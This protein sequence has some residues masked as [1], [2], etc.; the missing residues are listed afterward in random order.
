MIAWLILWFKCK[1]KKLS[2][3]MLC[4]ISKTFKLAD[5]TNRG[6]L[7]KIVGFH[8]K[9]T[10]SNMVRCVKIIVYAKNDVYMEYQQNL[11]IFFLRL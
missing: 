2:F 8:S 1:H 4:L 6:K 7:F 3:Y 10:S 11:H 9:E 5:L